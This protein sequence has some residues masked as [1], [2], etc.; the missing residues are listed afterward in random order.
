MATFYASA[1]EIDLTPPV[2][3]WMTG[4]AA[5]VAPTT[6]IHDPLMARALL[7]DA[8]HSR[9]AIVSCDLLGFAPQAVAAMRRR[10][11]Q[12]SAIPAENVLIACTHTHSGP[13]SMPLR[14][15]LGCVDA[16]W[17]AAAQDKI[18]DLVAGLP[19]HLAPAL[20]AHGAVDVP[21][22]GYNRQ[23]QAHPVD[24]ELRALA[25]E[26]ADGR[27]IATVVH[28]AT[29]AVVLGP[30]NLLYSG[31]FPGAAARHL[32]RLRGGIGLYLQG[33]CGDVDPTVN[34]DRGWGTGTFADCERIGERLASAAI[35]ALEHRPRTAD[36]ALCLVHKTLS[37][38]LDPPPSPEALAAMVSGFEADLHR[39][40]GDPPDLV[41]QQV[42]TA[43][44]RWA[45]ELQHALDA[46]A[47]PRSLQA[48]L[49]LADLNDLRLAGV[50]FEP[51]GDIGAGIKGALAPRPAF[52][53]G[54]ANGLHGYC[55]SRWA[56]D[57]GGYG[58]DSSARWFSGLLTAIGYGADDLIVAESISI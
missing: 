1:A 10:I 13:A 48:E 54:Y 28:Y 37:I 3:G 53:V 23:D 42:A 17:L 33:A 7:L 8:G 41:Q 57:Q 58:P 34:R 20:F 36:L 31:D 27:A 56:K 5:R 46:G 52:L 51:Y 11:A 55:P 25:F 14:G 32:A 2:G 43:M 44:L 9:L 26:T 35:K 22:I 16:A 12:Q 40:Q 47:V 45:A 19:A 38:P 21:G 29:H 49:F 18:V 39:A 15:I 24:S 4:F 50:P 30:S 6:G